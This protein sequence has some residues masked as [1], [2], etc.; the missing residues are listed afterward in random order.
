MVSAH[1]ELV[2]WSRY[3]ETYMRTIFLSSARGDDEPF[4]RRLYDDLT[5]HGFDVW[6]DRVSMPSRQFTFFQEIRDASAARERLDSGEFRV[7][8]CIATFDRR[9]SFL[10]AFSQL[11][12]NMIHDWPLLLTRS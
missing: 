8:S 1:A 3:S 2:T 10:L 5:V 12:K 11:E 4:V 6:F 9:Q 7:R